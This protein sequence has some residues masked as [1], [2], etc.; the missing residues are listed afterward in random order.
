MSKAWLPCLA[1]MVTGAFVA[2]AA[3]TNDF[4]NVV[5]DAPDSGSSPSPSSTST[6]APSSP[7]PANDT[8]TPSDAASPMDAA[9]LDGGDGGKLEQPN[10]SPCTKDSDNSPEC[11]SGFC[12]EQNSGP[13]NG[14]FCTIECD[15]DGQDDPKCAPTPPF[16][17][18]CSNGGDCLVQ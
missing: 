5:G 4:S 2:L 15:N 17:G 13:K 12:K 1:V 11:Q 6:D 14:F 9:K 8:G 7:P 16:T 10:G 3:C 18:K